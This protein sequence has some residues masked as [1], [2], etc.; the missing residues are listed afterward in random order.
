M[1]K[2]WKHLN[3][4]QRKI[5]NNALSKKLSCKEIGELID[6]DPTTISKE[7][8]RNRS[9]FNQG[10]TLTKQVCHQIK[11]FPFVCNACSRRYD[12]CELTTYVYKAHEAQELADARLIHSRKGLNID[13]E[14]FN[15]LNE[16]VHQ[17][18]SQKQSIY[19]IVHD[20]PEINVSV[21]TVYR[22]I[23]NN[24]LST[25]AI[26]LPR[27]V[28]L[29]KR[30]SKATKK[31]DYSK[32]KIDRTRRT[33]IDFL[34]FKHQYP[35]RFHAQMDFLGK[36]RSDVNSILTL[37][38]PDLHF[39]LLF[40]VTSETAVV[41]H[42]IIDDLESR[43]GIENFKKI[44]PFILT[45]RDPAFSN[46]M[47]FEYSPL[48]GEL[49]TSLFYCDAFT[50]VQ[51]ASVENMNG[52]LRDFFPKKQSIDHLTQEDIRSINYQLLHRRVASLNGANPK[53]AFIKV[54]GE[55]LYK[56]LVT[57]E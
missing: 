46:F 40:L 31:Y 52:Q 5:I 9:L 50:S 35:G 21:S 18:V 2:H 57:F 25:A 42:G 19:H 38:L 43:L 32:N 37:T 55:D 39:V 6:V 22:Y 27:M 8:K 28:K 33:Y 23:K 34:A 7:I 49:R 24:V 15:K 41:V 47:R 29:K 13:P 30:R 54:Y 45:D 48:T 16:L 11:R 1:N 44:F 14:S 26:D 12:L 20:N 10:V 17:G 3:F 53:E 36:I 51:K 4:E 56:A